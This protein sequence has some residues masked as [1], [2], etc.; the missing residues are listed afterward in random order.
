M[1][2]PVIAA[3]KAQIIEYAAERGLELKPEDI[4][5]DLSLEIRPLYR[6]YGPV[7]MGRRDDR[8]INEINATPG[9]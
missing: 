9:R 4:T 2:N 1:T 8:R 7:R 3:R 6:R 5:Y